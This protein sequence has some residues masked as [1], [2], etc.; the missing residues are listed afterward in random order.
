MIVCDPTA[1]PL[2]VNVAIVT[3]LVVLSVPVPIVVE[4]SWNVTLPVGSPAPGLIGATVAVNVSGCPK[5]VV[6]ADGV[7]TVVVVS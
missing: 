4:P 2:V 5:T 1:S 6:D 7:T 3:P